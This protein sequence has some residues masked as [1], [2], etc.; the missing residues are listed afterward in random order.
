MPLL[1]HLY[2]YSVSNNLNDSNINE[3]PLLDKSSNNN[4]EE[5]EN[6]VFLKAENTSPSKKGD[7]E[8]E[9]NKEDKPTPHPPP[10][11]PS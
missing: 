11:P 6:P 4:E 5:Y 9:E 1:Q 10:G 3:E 2:G 7:N 8:D